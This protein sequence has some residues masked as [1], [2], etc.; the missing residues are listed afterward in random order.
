[1]ASGV[2][3]AAWT[4]PVNL[5]RSGTDCAGVVVA[6][7]S[8][9]RVHA[10]ISRS[11]QGTWCCYVE[12]DVR[13]GWQWLSNGVAPAVCGDGLGRAHAVWSEGWEIRYKRWWNGAWESETATVS[14]STGESVKC[15]VCADSQNNVHVVWGKGGNVWY[16]RRSAATGQWD[17]PQQITFTSDMEGYLPPRI[18]AVGTAPVVVWGRD[19]GGEVRSVWFSCRETGSW[20]HT[21]LPTAHT[22]AS[23]C[24]IDVTPSGEV[25]CTWDDAYDIWHARRV[26][27]TWYLLGVMT[28]G[29]SSLSPRISAASSSKVDLV[30]R[31]DAS[32][33]GDMYTSRW[34]G[35]SWSVPGGVTGPWT[36]G[37]VL[38]DITHDWSGG[39]CPAYSKGWDIWLITDLT[40]DTMAPPAPSVD[41]PLNGDSQVTLSWT[42]PEAIDLFRVRVVYRTDRY[43]ATPVD[44]TTIVDRAA[45]WGTDSLT[46]TSLTNGTQY[47]YSIFLCDEVPNWSPAANVTGDP[48]A[49]TC[50]QAEQMAEN[51]PVN[52]KGK[53]VSAVFPSDSCIYVQEANRT[54][55]IRVA[56]SGTGIAAGDRVD[57]SGYVTTRM[58]SSRASERQ[59]TT[60]TVTKTSTA[61]AP[62]P[63]GM[64]CRAVGGAAV[65]PNVPGV[66]DAIGQNNMG[67]LVRFAGKVTKVIGSYIYVDD[68]SGV[69]NASASAPEIGVMVK[70]AVTPTVVAGD[71]VAVTGV[72]VGSIPNGWTANRAYVQTRT[73]GDVVKVN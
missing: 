8:A 20:V 70:C 71:K 46:H 62:R 31:D 22:G 53:V 12:N 64:T 69:V 67:L 45:S 16:N 21:Q 6:A 30:W 65:P 17:G 3:H 13:R 34:S 54:S 63:L 1:M 9:G 2:A 29:S 33:F 15:D 7:D 5:T 60:A 50:L 44:G 39:Q 61:G 38:P 40:P 52:L 66:R 57:I 43:P 36:A 11:G 37:V 27:G 18:G 51:Q 56:W 68:G 19:T 49:T 35:T 14:N 55:G 23:A 32:G 72:I 4:P 28:T 59:I 25:H 10:L 73:G 24:D 48:F 42:N 26:N 58:V 47:C 41:Q